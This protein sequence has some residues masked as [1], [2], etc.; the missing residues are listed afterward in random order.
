MLQFVSCVCKLQLIAGVELLPKINISFLF[1]L[2]LVSYTGRHQWSKTFCEK[3]EFQ[4]VTS[5]V[6]VVM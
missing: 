2:V 4:T 1:S 6:Y 3:L 5:R